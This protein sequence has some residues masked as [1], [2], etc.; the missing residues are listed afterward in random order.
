MSSVLRRDL[1]KDSDLSLVDLIQFKLS[2]YLIKCG[3][4][5]GQAAFW[6][7][8]KPIVFVNHNLPF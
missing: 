7:I 5:K 1:E 2:I 6:Q 4:K 3:K 8:H